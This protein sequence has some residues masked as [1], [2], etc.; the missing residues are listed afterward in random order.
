MGLGFS[1]SDAKRIADAVKGWEKFQPI[2]GTSQTARPRGNQI[3][4][5]KLN[6]DLSVDTPVDGVMQRP[7]SDFTGFEDSDVTLKNIYATDDDTSAK[8]DDVIWVTNWGNQW[9]E[10][11]GGS[12]PTVNTVWA[13]LI[14]G[15]ALGGTFKIGKKVLSTYTW[16]SA[17]PYNPSEA[18]IRTAVDSVWGSGTAGEIAQ[19]TGGFNTHV[20]FVGDYEGTAPPAL[21]VDSSGLIGPGVGATSFLLREG[22]V[23]DG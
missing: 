19:S 1:E 15:P 16:S 3:V 2:L 6:D 10:I 5:V 11:G 9:Y 4:R 7:N 17:I 12:C 20:E 8:A 13:I 22:S 14:F 23:S 21:L 18:N